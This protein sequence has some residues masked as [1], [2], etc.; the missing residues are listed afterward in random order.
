MGGERLST[1]AA[2]RA[3][4]LPLKIALAFAATSLP[5]QALLIAVAVHL[6]AY[7]AASIGVELAVVAAAFGTVRLLDVPI[8]PALGLAM[9]RTRTRLGRYRVW[10]VVGAPLLMLGLYMLLVAREGVGVGYLIAWL[11][12]MYLG[13]SILMLS[14]QAWAACLARSYDDRARLFGVMGAVGV[15]GAITV[16]AIPIVMER[17]GYP[18]AEGVRA[19]VWYLIALVPI[20][21]AVVVTRTPEPI[22][23]EPPGARFRARDYLELVTDPSMLRILLADLALSLGPGWMAALYL[24]Y[25]RDSL[26]FSAGEANLLLGVY[27]LSG[28]VGAP[29]MAWL[30]TKIS[31]HRTVMVTAVAYSLLLIALAFAPR[32][33]FAAVL[34]IMF[35]TGCCFAG[36]TVLTRAMTADVADEVRL[37]QGKERSGLL[38]ALTTLTSKIASGGSIFLTFNVLAGVGY[39]PQI[40]DANSPEAVRALELAFLSGPIL[41]VMLGAVCLI[42]YRLTAERAAEVRRHLEARDAATAPDPAPA[43]SGAAQPL[44][45]HP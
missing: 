37:K 45:A 5:L 10:T 3:D 9:D 42:G 23:A 13:V 7:F 6:P 25:F 8:E 15:T 35:L 38:Y 19:M 4:R 21:I 14:H 20:A 33:S 11:M 32:G 30:A 27:I 31:K 18:D 39:D 1:A 34:P 24:F 17:M 36:F 28:L 43:A 44:E 26:G 22:W 12:V 40:G 2:G 16:L 41:F 29:F